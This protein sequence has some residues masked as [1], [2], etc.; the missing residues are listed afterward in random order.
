MQEVTAAK[1]A[2]YR[3][4]SENLGT[5]TGQKFAEKLGEMTAIDK[6]LELLLK[7]VAEVT[8]E[9]EEIKQGLA[10]T[11][12]IKQ[13]IRNEKR[14]IY[15]EVSKII[16]AMLHNFEQ[17]ITLSKRVNIGR[18][19]NLIM[20]QELND[21]IRNQAVE[22]PDE[23]R[24]F[25]EE[26]H[27]LTKSLHESRM[28]LRIYCSP[29]ALGALNHYDSQKIE[30]S[31]YNYMEEV[32]RNMRKLEKGIASIA[33]FDLG[34][35]IQPF[36]MEGKRWGEQ[37]QSQIICPKCLHAFLVDLHELNQRRLQHQQEMQLG[38]LS[39]YIKCSK[40]LQR[41]EVSL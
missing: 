40:C 21:Q 33:S 9:T 5:I 35:P 19:S 39:S 31:N 41:F 4:I 17:L 27:R 20:L 13:A 15:N 29:A 30:T 11:I 23:F 12:W 26:H 18:S 16:G 25:M 1:E 14:S 36:P 10:N 38:E 32:V 34:M 6:N 2:E 28:S 22:L 24:P 8:R 37:N 3:T 7:Q